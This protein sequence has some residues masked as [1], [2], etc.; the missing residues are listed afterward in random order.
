M[1]T[2]FGQLL[3]RLRTERGLSRAK[4]AA[5]SGVAESTIVRA[6]QEPTCVLKLTKLANITRGLG[7]MSAEDAAEWLDATGMRPA[8][9]ATRAASRSDNS[10]FSRALA[11]I[12]VHAEPDVATAHAWVQELSERSSPG[13]VLDVLK[14]MAAFGGYDLLPRFTSSDIESFK[15]AMNPSAVSRTINVVSP[16]VQRDG[17]VEQ[18]VVTYEAVEERKPAAGKAGHGRAKRA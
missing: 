10:E 2:H 1:T 13:A 17:Y 11:S 3:F 7:A 12:Y 18:R 15:V 8:L 14:A 9:E 6:E 16:P 4:L 5:I